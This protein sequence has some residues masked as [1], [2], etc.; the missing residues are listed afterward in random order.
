MAFHRQALFRAKLGPLR[1]K[2]GPFRAKLGPL[3]ALS[4]PRE[5]SGIGARASSSQMTALARRPGEA[6]SGRI[7]RQLL[8]L[9]T[10]SA[11]PLRAR[12]GGAG[13]DWATI[14]TARRR[15]IRL[16]RLTWRSMRPIRPRNLQRCPTL[17]AFRRWSAQRGLRWRPRPR[18]LRRPRPRLLRRP[19]GLR[20][21]RRHL[22][23]R[24]DL[25]GRTSADGPRRKFWWVHSGQ[26]SPAMSLTS[27]TMSPSVQCCRP[28][29]V[30]SQ[31]SDASAGERR[32]PPRSVLMQKDLP[33]RL[34][35]LGRATL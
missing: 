21:L 10:R 32:R 23:R 31:S 4:W 25:G 35:S 28:W 27:V 9:T 29:P 18:H 8:R 13:G 17:R 12:E 11:Q 26:T 20:R 16:I 22:H 15:S 3:V 1:A 24:T 7:C 33:L 34:H 6:P 30:R 5:C 14:M 19:R 2:L